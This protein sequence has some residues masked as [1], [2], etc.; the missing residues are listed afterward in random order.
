MTDRVKGLYVSLDR[1]IRDDDVESVMN[2]IR[3]VKCVSDVTHENLVTDPADYF[4]RD[5]IR[6]ELMDVCYTVFSGVLTG[7]VG[8]CRDKGKV[9]AALSQVIEKL[10]KSP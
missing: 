4:A 10:R 1:D 6:G 8:Y 2:A 7:N 9:I 5:R 3:M